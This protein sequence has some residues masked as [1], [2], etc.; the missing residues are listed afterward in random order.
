LKKKTAVGISI[1]R[2][3]PQVALKPF[4]GPKEAEFALP[5]E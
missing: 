2:I 4:S 1:K 3:K 5:L